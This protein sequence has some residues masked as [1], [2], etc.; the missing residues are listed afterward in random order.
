M[1]PINEWEL[2]SKTWTLRDMLASEVIKKGS[3]STMFAHAIYNLI[4][5]R[6]DDADVSDDDIQDLSLQELGVVSERIAEKMAENLRIEV[7]MSQMALTIDSLHKDSKP[8]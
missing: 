7:A 4:K 2:S 8:S 6:V 3:Q 1:K 5:G